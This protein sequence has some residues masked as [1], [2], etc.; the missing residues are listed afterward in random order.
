MNVKR[1]NRKEEL[2]WKNIAEKIETNSLFKELLELR[3]KKDYIAAEKI[4]EE[5]CRRRSN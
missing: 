2:M 3:E 1:R 4:L 5:I